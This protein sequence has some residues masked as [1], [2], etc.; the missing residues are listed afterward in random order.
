[1]ANTEEIALKVL[2][3]ADLVCLCFSRLFDIDLQCDGILTVI[4]MTGAY[5]VSGN[6]DRPKD[7]LVWHHKSIYPRN[8]VLLT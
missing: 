4:T 8:T 2:C 1:M 7:K 6:V 5:P 3:A